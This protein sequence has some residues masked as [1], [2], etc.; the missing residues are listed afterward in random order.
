[1]EAGKLNSTEALGHYRDDFRAQ[2][3]PYQGGSTVEV[4]IFHPGNFENSPSSLDSAPLSSSLE[5][6]EDFF[7]G[8]STVETENCQGGST[9]ERVLSLKEAVDFYKISERTIRLHI[10]QG[11]I[12]AS[13]ATGPRG[14]EWR[15][16]PDRQPTI[17]ESGHLTTVEAEELQSVTRVENDQTTVEVEQI[18]SA[19]TVAMQHF[20]GGSTVVTEQ[21]SLPFQQLDKLLEVIKEQSEKLEDANRKLESANYRIGYLEAQSQT[22]QEQIKLLT[23]SQHKPS[24]WQK[25]TSWMTRH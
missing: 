23:D 25:L 14:P 19:S 17:E 9:V 5:G 12:I 7:H 3:H 21:L 2:Q 10:A 18:Q 24:W 20:Q 22:Y 6:L 1:M 13:K 8:G 11:K 16:Y 4:E 15:I